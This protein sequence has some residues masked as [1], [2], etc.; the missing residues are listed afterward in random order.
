MLI[1]LLQ[2]SRE[3]VIVSFC[4]INVFSSRKEVL[5]SG[6][7][8]GECNLHNVRTLCVICHAKVTAEQSQKRRKS[9]ARAKQAFQVTIERFIEKWCE[10]RMQTFKTEVRLALNQ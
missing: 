3:E 7:N 10:K 2:S 6:T 4:T 9:F 1:I 8:A 5:S